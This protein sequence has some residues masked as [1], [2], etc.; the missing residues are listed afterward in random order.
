M[1][2]YDRC[3]EMGYI[4][5]PSAIGFYSPDKAALEDSIR[6]AFSNQYGAGE[7]PKVSSTRRSQWVAGVA[8]HAGFIYSGPVASHLYKA[9]AQDG[10]PETF[11]LIGPK[12]RPMRVQGAAVMAE[13]SWETP[14][15]TCQIDRPL[16]H[17]LLEQCQDTGIDCI[18][19]S[20]HAHD[21]EHSLEV[22]LPFLQFLG[23]LDSFKIV[24][25]VISS[26]K[27]TVCEKVG[28]T[29]ADAIQKS[30]RDVILLA[31]TDFTHYGQFHFGYAPVGD[32]P[33]E[34]V[35]QWVHETDAELIEKIE[36]LDG[37]ALL[38]TVINKRR[39]MCGASAVT[40][41]IV[42]AKKLGAVKGNLLKYATSYDVRGSPGA[43]VGYA[44]L[45]IQR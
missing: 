9:I 31:S 14:L 43:I 37:K 42:A 44:A 22:Q 35:A 20:S 2:I 32:G 24:P 23:G 11:V 29:I 15:G 8:P 36:K 34:K 40:T 7:I 13:G 30:G 12:H 19:E 17:M 10:F 21:D 26:Q 33:I 6:D 38:N 18:S 3:D 45:T 16:A 4:R 5:Q 1:K 41:A 27:F 28:I 25:L 39:T